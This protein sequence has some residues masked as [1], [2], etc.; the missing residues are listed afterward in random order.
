ME[1]LWSLQN[2]QN[3]PYKGLFD[4]F[5]HFRSQIGILLAKIGTIP[6][7]YCL[8]DTLNSLLVL[9]KITEKA[10]QLSKVSD[11]VTHDKQ[12]HVGCGT[13]V[14]EVPRGAF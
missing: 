9:Y 1:N 7:C 4:I 10:K 14:S 2:E 13:P 8:L 6:R 3:Y 5:G 11:V 12:L